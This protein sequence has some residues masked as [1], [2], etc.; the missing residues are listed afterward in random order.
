MQRKSNDT[1]K[2]QN[3]IHVIGIDASGFDG[4][5]I[6]QIE[7]ILESRKI[8]G[9]NRILEMFSSW[10][11]KRK[12]EFEEPQ[13]IPNNNTKEFIKWLKEESQ[14]IV[15][16]ASGDPLWFGIGRQLLNNFPSNRL[17]FY[18]SVTSLQLAFSRLG[19]PWQDASWISI[20]GREPEELASN[21]Q[22]Q[23]SALVILTD[24]SRGGAKEVKECLQGIGLEE[25]YIF[26]ICEQL[27]HKDERIKRIYPGEKISEDI[28]PLHLVVLIKEENVKLKN[29]LPLFG[30]KDSLFLQY[31]DR[32]GLMTKRETRVQLLAELELP[33]EGVIWDIGAGVGSIGLEALRLR[34]KLKLVSIDKRI[35]CEE[36]I[37]AN[38]EKLNVKVSCIFESEILELLKQQKIPHEFIKPDRIIL[39]GG[40]PKRTE[41]LNRIIEYLN[42]GGI[43]IIPLSTLEALS[44][45]GNVL[46]ASNFELTIRS[47]QS[48]RGI[49]LGDGTRLAPMNPVFIIKGKL[50]N[51]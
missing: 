44:D 21:L 43:I 23:P 49:P 24:P 16:L 32:P 19:R 36:L 31:K 50:N 3:A 18:P 17:H 14:S 11:I 45:L 1:N 5:S 34:T 39:G 22:K 30:I 40:G 12:S 9:P 27:G 25:I 8:A 13:L 38:S 28:N 15:I 4:L 42:P 2:S 7:L 47:I 26:W 35:G 46:K 10:W 41:I 6:P 51:N 48:Y 33:E 29:K 37:K 20:H